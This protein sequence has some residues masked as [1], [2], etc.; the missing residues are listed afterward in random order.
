MEIREYKDTDKNSWIRCRVVSFMDSS[1]YDDVQNF[2]EK[3]QNPSV[4]LVAV[5]NNSVVGFLDVEYE[6]EPGDVC[7]FK[8]QKGGVIWH[9]GALP[10]F[11]NQKIATM[12]W[13]KAKEMLINEGVK[14]IEVWT[15][16]D[17][18]ATKWYV[19]QGFQMKEAYLNAFVRGNEKTPIIQKYINFNSIGE[20]YGI[21][22]LNFE[23][24]IERK[25]ELEKVCY[26]LYEVRVYEVYL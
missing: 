3:Y 11:R 25:S 15:Q 14:R 23:A 26:R 17:E 12:L 10:E 18:P 9:L 8:G 5:D 1:Y 6:N 24:P 2:R 16:D 4:K 22:S 21:R 7:Y 19:K 13:N 20:I